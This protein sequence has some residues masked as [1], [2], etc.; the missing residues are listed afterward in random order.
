MGIKWLGKSHRSPVSCKEIS[1]EQV[2]NRLQSRCKQG[3]RCKLG[4][5][6]VWRLFLSKG[7]NVGWFY[8]SFFFQFLKLNIF[9]FVVAI[10]D[11]VHDVEAIIHLP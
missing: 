4:V 9:S 8:W 2:A 1:R 6:F 5:T 7:Y 10:C 11:L 3:L